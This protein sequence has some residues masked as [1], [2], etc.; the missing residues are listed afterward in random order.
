[1]YSNAVATVKPRY[2]IR[3]EEVE[4]P[5]GANEDAECG[6]NAETR[7]HFRRGKLLQNGPHEFFGSTA[8]MLGL[9]IEIVEIFLIS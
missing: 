2:A 6:E 5:E 3:R 8:G 9:A 1:M 4:G 7:K